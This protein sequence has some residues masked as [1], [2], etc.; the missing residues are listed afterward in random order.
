MAEDTYINVKDLPEVTEIVNGDYILIET[1]E[2][3]NII[4]FENF[5]LPT[6][7]T[8]ITTLATE[9]TTAILSLSADTNAKLSELEQK[10]NLLSAFAVAKASISIPIDSS[11]GNG[12]LLFEPS[13]TPTLTPLT[14]ED[15]IIVPAN[16]YAAE[17]SYFISNFA[18]NVVTITGIFKTQTLDLIDTAPV[19]IP[20]SKVTF[21][22]STS[23]L[24]A[25][26]GTTPEYQIDVADLFSKV[27]LKTNYTPA[28][29]EAK[30]NI[31]AIKKF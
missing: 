5:I 27:V 17:N 10:V 8:V 11:T 21:S 14:L 6:A 26:S 15:I 20:S 30:Y 31:F 23:P 16:Q 18:Q 25:L 29:Q 19:I 22:G 28:T 12:V 9:N 7:N 1:P 4:N 13:N 3:T 24:T 2:G